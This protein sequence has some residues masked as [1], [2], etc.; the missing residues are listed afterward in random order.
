V[1]FSIDPS[2]SQ[3][4]AHLFPAVK[5]AGSFYPLPG[6]TGLSGK[7]QVGDMTLLARQQQESTPMPGI[8]RRREY[9]ILRRL[10][11]SGLAPVMQGYNRRWLLLQWQTGRT[12]TPNEFAQR[13]PDITAQMVALHQQPLSGFRLL[14]LPLLEQYWLLSHASRRHTRWLSALR[15]CQRQGEPRPLRLALLHMDIHPGNI[16]TQTGDDLHLIDWEY[17]S[18]GDVALE[19]AATIAGNDLS[20]QQQASLI[21][22]YAA[23]QQ[24]DPAALRLQI[25]RW[26]PWLRLLIACWYERRW[27]QSGDKLY[28]GL[29]AE[30]WQQI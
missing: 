10:R 5:S 20:M 25:C 4:I 18:D 17:A 22:D 2:L 8:D 21:A 19:L 29:A 1:S 3:L 23:Q 6:L 30:A 13:L 9:H 26:Q 14:L 7:L 24:L 16:V 27:Q 11:G 12:L 28:D 15:R